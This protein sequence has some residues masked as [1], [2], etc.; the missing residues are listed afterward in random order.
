MIKLYETNS[1]LR[2]NQTTVTFSEAAT[3]SDGNSYGLIRLDE[4]IFFPEEGGQYADTGI[5][6]VKDGDSSYD[7][8]LLDGQIENGI[9]TYKISKP[10]PNGALVECRLDWDKRFMRMQNHSGEHVLTGVVHNRYGLN[11][12]GFHL[13][14]DDFVTLDFDGVLSYEQILEMEREANSIIYEDVPIKDS[15]PTRDELDRISYRSKIE[16]EGQVRLITIGDD[17]KT[18]DVCACCAPHVSSTGMI[19]IIKV[20]SVIKWKKGIQVAILCGDRALSYINKEHSL[21][22]KIARDF[23][24]SPDNIPGVI[25]GHLEE[26]ADLKRRL[27]SATQSSLLHQLDMLKESDPKTVFTDAELT[28][29]DMKTIY[30][31]MISRFDGFV[32][33]FCGNDTTGY[34]FN[35]GGRNL[36]ARELSGILRDKFNA[37]GGG[38]A[39]MIQ[40]KITASMADIKK[41][42]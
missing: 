12:C 26:I 37:K 39:E 10:I 5:I 30:N 40:G 32:G 14:D 6:R 21:I 16:I 2:Q 24:T 29:N 41:V 1:L 28:A 18:Y 27:S 7:V 25:A 42:F 9:V 20:I 38:S 33:V 3:D 35:A 34:R 22:T 23:S 15:Y 31:E 8:T 36:D 11:N 19:G 4:S 17:T 13:S